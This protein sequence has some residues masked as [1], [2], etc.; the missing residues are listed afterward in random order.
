MVDVRRLHI[1]REVARQGSFAKAAA[2]LLLTPSAVS[3]QIAALERSLGLPVVER[4]TRGVRLTEPGRIMVDAADAVAAELADAQ[5]RIS[6][7]VDGHTGSLCLDTFS[8]GGQL[9]LPDA[10]SRLLA[11]QPGVELAVAEADLEE[12]VVHVREGSA[13]LALTFHFDGPYMP[14]GA[15]SWTPLLR[16]PLWVV[17]PDGH[18]LAGRDALALAELA[19]EPWV[20]GCML[21]AQA[22]DQ[23]AA[24][25]GFRPRVVCRSSDYVFAQSLVAA[26]VGISLIPETALA[27]SPGPS[28]RVGS[29]G[30][31]G[32]PGLRG[33]TAVPLRGPG[34]SRHIGALTLRRRWPQPLVGR[35]L[36]A[37][38][39]TAAGLPS[40]GAHGSHRSVAPLAP[41]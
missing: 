23:Y 15:L 19:D 28:G 32:H 37:L 40:T 3:Q 4:S 41:G 34:P 27:T 11:E 18:R 12:S 17:L 30:P 22:I 14:E 35:L 25:A 13:D 36:Q 9:L 33:L 31:G 21:A 6:E 24:V 39:D 2:V 1:L 7:L 29:S 20:L 10:L 8:S 5:C 26:G 16:D 38:R